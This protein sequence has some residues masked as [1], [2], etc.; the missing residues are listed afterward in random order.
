MAQ[1][2]ELKS[3][4]VFF[5]LVGKLKLEKRKGWVDRGVRGCE[6]VADHSFR[7]ALMSF[8]FAEKQK[9]DAGRALKL[10]VVHD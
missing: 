9:L 6:S 7:L 10:A 3:I 1:E 5:H 8:V 2:S 4:A